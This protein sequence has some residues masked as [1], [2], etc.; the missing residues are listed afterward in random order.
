MHQGINVCREGNMSDSGSEFS[1][2]VLDR[3]NR[4]RAARSAVQARDPSFFAA[5]SKAMFERDPIGINFTDN[6]DE[7]DPEAGTVIPRLAACRS[8][9]E[10]AQVLLEEFQSWFGAETA[11][12]LPGYRTLAAD[13]WL[14]H[15]R[16]DA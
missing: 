11:G 12:D 10:V 1:L 6:T 14:L 7:Y 4:A 16:H 9:E 8:T 3:I 15:G 13:L 5:V 2:E